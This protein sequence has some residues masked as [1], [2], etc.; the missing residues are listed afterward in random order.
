MLHHYY[1]KSS[2]LLLFFC[3]SGHFTWMQYLHVYIIIEFKNNVNLIIVARWHI[4]IIF[5]SSLLA[6]YLV[7]TSMQYLHIIIEFKNNVNLVAWWHIYI[8]FISSLL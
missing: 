3:Y 7:I 1:F 2:V 8:I 6:H 4:Y 5:I